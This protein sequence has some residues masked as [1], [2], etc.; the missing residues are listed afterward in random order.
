MN[1][2][3]S[4][5]NPLTFLFRM[6]DALQE[7]LYYEWEFFLHPEKWPPDS[8]SLQIRQQPSTPQANAVHHIYDPIEEECVCEASSRGNFQKVRGEL[9]SSFMVDNLN[10]GARALLMDPMNPVYKLHSF[11]RNKGIYES[12]KLVNKNYL[13]KDSVDLLQ[14][15]VSAS[16]TA[17]PGPALVEA[18]KQV[19]KRMLEMKVDIIIDERSRWRKL[20]NVD[21][22]DSSAGSAKKFNL[23]AAISK[24]NK[25]SVISTTGKGESEKPLYQFRRFYKTPQNQNETQHCRMAERRNAIQMKR[26]NASMLCKRN[27]QS[28]HMRIYKLCDIMKFIEDII[29]NFYLIKTRNILPCKFEVMNEVFNIYGLTLLSSIKNYIHEYDNYTAKEK[30][31]RVLDPR[32]THLD[33]RHNKKYVRV[34]TRKAYSNPDK[35]S[36][37]KLA[38]MH[39]L[40][41]CEGRI[42]YA[43][44]PIE[45]CYLFYR[46]AELYYD[47]DEMD[48]AYKCA[49]KVL[50]V[51]AQECKNWVWRF[52]GWIMSLKAIVVSKSCLEIP[53][54]LEA[55]KYIADHLDHDSQQY[56][57]VLKYYARLV[58]LEARLKRPDCLCVTSDDQP[59]HACDC[60]KKVRRMIEMNEMIPSN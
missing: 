44:F 34:S 55:G 13:S 10:N 49:N 59:S 26:R 31:L 46:M 14:F 35:L 57:I 45:R 40:T 30:L 7:M 5:W 41:E 56:F 24:S 29:S 11:Y 8:L 20:G 22:S 48:K 53:K 32:N 37:N 58:Y 19:L 33:R 39:E 50:C 6:D 54:C 27:A 2:S 28:K 52:L 16:I 38:K 1:K 23:A 9:Q 51:H 3:N 12:Y 4:P 36:A 60:K 47:Q 25:V 15:N 21:K 43:I 18:Q 17:C 42:N